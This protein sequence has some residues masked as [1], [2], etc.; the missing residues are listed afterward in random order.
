MTWM[1]LHFP[2]WSHGLV[3]LHHPS[4]LGSPHEQPDITWGL[5]ILRGQDAHQYSATKA[6]QKVC[7]SFLPFI[8]AHHVLI[9]SNNTT[10]V[11]YISKGPPPCVQRQSTSGTGASAIKSPYQLL[12]KQNMLT[13][14]VTDILQLTMCGSFTTWYS[15]IFTLWENPQ[16][17]IYLS[18]ANSKCT[19]F[20][21]R[22][23]QGHYSQGDGLL[24]GK[25]SSPMPSFCY[26]SCHNFCV[27]SGRAEQESA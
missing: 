23:A 13:D 17:R 7:E 21:S 26:C 22:G 16:P 14:S 1:I 8:C 5:G 3:D 12:G 20:C 4:R 19:T 25:T 18:Q 15:N 24:L 10:T 2:A 11:F 6:V 9:K 27:R